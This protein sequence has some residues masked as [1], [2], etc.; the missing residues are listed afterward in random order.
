MRAEEVL[1]VLGA[2]QQAGLRVWL[3]GGWGV[4][5]LLGEVTR[6]HDDVDLVVE[7]DA[8]PAV[9]TA[10]E[11]LAFRLVE[12]H[13]PTRAVLRATDGRQVDLH[14]VRFDDD[15]TGWQLGASPDGSDCGHPVE[16]FGQGRIGDRVVPC[17]TPELQLAHHL[18]YPPRDRD[19]LDVERLAGRFGLTL[20]DGW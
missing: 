10:L 5:A 11:P 1:A 7:L 9:V 6:R 8:V 19:R 17:L 2:M 18:G 4:D 20:G 3:D 14:P 13:L 15:G 16:G 12:D